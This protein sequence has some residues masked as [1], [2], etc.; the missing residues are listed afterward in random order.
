M[1]NI[2]PK[3]EELQKKYA[4]DPQKLSE[5]TMKVFKNE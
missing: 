3:I 2:Q 1:S 5:E 4:D